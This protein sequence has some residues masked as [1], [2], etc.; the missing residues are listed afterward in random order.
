M[1]EEEEGRKGRMRS[2]F[3]KSSTTMTTMIYQDYCKPV[4]VQIFANIVALV[5]LLLLLL[6]LPLIAAREL[7][8]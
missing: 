1:A 2:L 4:D 7:L 8:S 3:I 5:L 6:L